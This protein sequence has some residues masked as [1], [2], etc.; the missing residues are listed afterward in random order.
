MVKYCYYL[1]WPA[2]SG[3]YACG[4]E[5]FWAQWHCKRD[6]R[7]LETHTRRLYGPIP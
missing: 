3:T 5:S 2:L 7:R 4:P 1:S 6:V